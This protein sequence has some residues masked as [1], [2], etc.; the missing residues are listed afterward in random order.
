[1]LVVGGDS[2]GCGG[3]RCRQSHG[4]RTRCRTRLDSRALLRIS[5]SLSRPPPPHFSR[6]RVLASTFPFV[7][8]VS[9]H[10]RAL[11]SARREYALS[12]PQPRSNIHTR[13]PRTLIYD[14]IE[15]RA[16]HG[17]RL[18]NP[19]KFRARVASAIRDFQSSILAYF[20][21]SVRPHR[22]S[23]RPS[24]ICCFLLVRLC[25]FLFRSCTSGRCGSRRRSLI[26]PACVVVVVGG[27]GRTR[28][29]A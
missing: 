10:P 22:P 16:R 18:R 28:I 26:H 25:L 3:H 9:F 12:A 8:R 23:S 5:A 20:A 27:G 29:R 13:T 17:V 14:R 1:M 6:T 24:V 11:H 15:L 2:C 4:A 21:R 19:S 7:F